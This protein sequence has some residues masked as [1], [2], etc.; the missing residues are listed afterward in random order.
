MQNSVKQKLEKILLE[1]EKINKLRE[2][3]KTVKLSITEETKISGNTKS[4]SWKKEK[5][6]MMDSEEDD[7]IIVDFR[8]DESGSDDEEDF[9]ETTVINLCSM[10][11]Y[12]GFF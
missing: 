3:V 8:S 7:L 12:N 10:C 1:E 4:N 11:N 9:K 2:R 5:N 6:E